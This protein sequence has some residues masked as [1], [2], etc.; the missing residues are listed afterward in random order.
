MTDP[1]EI[2]ALIAQLPD[3]IQPLCAVVQGLLIHGELLAVY[4]VVEA[5]AVFSRD[6]MP[7]AARLQQIQEMDPRRLDIPRGPRERSIGTCRD[8]ALMMCGF[9]RVKGI[10]ARVRCGF[11]DY[12]FGVPWSD[13]WICE[14][15]S[16]SEGRWVRIDPQIDERQRSFYAKIDFDACDI[17][18]NRFMTAGEAWGSCRSGHIDPSVCGHGDAT[19]LWFVR[20]NVYR[21][22]LSVNHRETS[23]WDSWRQSRT[24]DQV[25]TEADFALTDHIAMNPE[26]EP[27]SSAIPPWQVSVSR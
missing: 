25:M 21:D 22:H 6:T 1:K 8:F 7:L 4:G 9:L 15:W 23:P 5:P 24:R 16:V 14:Y 26:A 10:A 2:E 12:F 13:H 27:A 20:V 17:P 19:G 11:V 18:L 3:G